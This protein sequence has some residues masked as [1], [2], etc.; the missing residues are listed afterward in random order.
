ML[1]EL[2]FSDSFKYLVSLNIVTDNLDQKSLRNNFG[3]I[4]H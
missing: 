4:Y 2:Q 3:N 1:V